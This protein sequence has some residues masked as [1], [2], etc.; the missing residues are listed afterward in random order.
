MRKQNTDRQDVQLLLRLMM[1]DRFPAD[2]GARG[3]ESRSA[4]SISQR[5][6]RP[7][8]AQSHDCDRALRSFTL[9]GALLQQPH[10]L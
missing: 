3:G 2:L 10:S 6:A 8:R 7:N 5:I 1:E 4:V 9:F